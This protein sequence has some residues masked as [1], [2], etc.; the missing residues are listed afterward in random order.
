[1]EAPALVQATIDIGDRWQVA[2]ISPISLVQF[3]QACV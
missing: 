3:I 2:G 1:V